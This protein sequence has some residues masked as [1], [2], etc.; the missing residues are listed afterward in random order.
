M[1]SKYSDELV[2]IFSKNI[3]SV[4]ISVE[5][6]LDFLTAMSVV[7]LADVLTASLILPELEDTLGLSPVITE[8]LYDAVMNAELPTSAAS[9]YELG[10]RLLS[11]PYPRMREAGIS[12]VL[13]AAFVAPEDE[14]TQLILD[15]IDDPTCQWDPEIWLLDGT[16]RIE[17]QGVPIRVV[18]R[19]LP[20]YWRR[21]QKDH[22]RAEDLVRLTSLK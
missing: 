19:V 8:S 1:P 6:L 22:G 16:H 15:A 5:D 9:R 12:L 18:L 3:D 4:A 14:L 11:S 17:D 13:D 21:L 2:A 10:K 20:H 7:D